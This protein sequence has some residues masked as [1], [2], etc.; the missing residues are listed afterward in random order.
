MRDI[1]ESPTAQLLA[2]D[3]KQFFLWEKQ[4][5]D[6]IITGLHQ[7]TRPPPSFFFAE[8]NTLFIPLADIFIPLT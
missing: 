4:K 8:L 2:V 3:I 1:Y 6:K 5:W 7:N